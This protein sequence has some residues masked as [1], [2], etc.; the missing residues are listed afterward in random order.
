[1]FAVGTSGGSVASPHVAL[2]AKGCQSTRYGHR[3]LGSARRQKENGGLEA[4]A[5]PDSSPGSVALDLRADLARRVLRAVD[6]DIELAGLERLVLLV[7]Q[8]RAGGSDEDV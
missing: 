6:V 7:A 4:A 3:S 5:S 2:T 8:L 1:M